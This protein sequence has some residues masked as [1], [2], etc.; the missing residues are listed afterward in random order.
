MHAKH[1]GHSLLGDDT[2]G[3]GGTG[4]LRAL[5]HA[6][7]VRLAAVKVALATFQRP[8]LH[9][10]TLA[11]Q[12]PAGDGAS[13]RRLEFGSELPDDFQTVLDALRACVRAGR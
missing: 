1:I 8:A 9:A 3:G 7:P 13:S 10:K 4:I 12:H 2:Y 6:T 11:F 5:S